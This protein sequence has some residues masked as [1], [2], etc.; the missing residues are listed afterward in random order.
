MIFENFEIAQISKF[1]K[2]H[3]GNLSKIALLNMWLLV[4]IPTNVNV[5][6]I[7]QAIV[8]FKHYLCGDISSL[9]THYL[10]LRHRIIDGHI[11]GFVGNDQKIN[12]C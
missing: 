12:G 5:S 4:L 9:K 8:P 1:S 11:L 3:S 6:L 2:K 7:Q 10:P